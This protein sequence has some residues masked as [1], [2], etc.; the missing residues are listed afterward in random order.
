MSRARLLVSIV[1]VCACG[2]GET[3]AD[4]GDPIDGG[5]RVDSTV[6]DAGM[7]DAGSADVDSGEPPIDAG[8]GGCTAAACPD[9]WMGGVNLAGADFGETNLPGVYDTHYIYPSPS[10]V[11]Y[12]VGRGMRAIR[13]PFRW[14]RLQR[15]LRSA[16]DATELARMESIVR[17]ATGLGARVILDPH[18][19]ARYHGALVGTSE[20]SN[21]DYADL[22]RRLALVFADDDRVIFGL[23]NE[24]HTMPTEQ[25]LAAANAAIAAIRGAGAQN[26]I[27]VP[28]NSYTGAFSWADS[29][30]GTPNAEVML[31]V[32]DP[33][34]RYAI[35]VHQYLDADS[36][37]RGA[38]CVSGTIGRERTV[39]FTS[40][41]RDN[42]LRGFLGE[43]GGADNAACEAA[44]HDLLSFIEANAD[45]WLGWTWWAAGPWWGDYM[46][47]IEPRGD[48]SDS[49]QMLWLDDHL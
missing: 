48:G 47:S 49:P 43:L 19:Y 15:S 31:G 1:W 27:L 12:F 9:E 30:Y 11:D 2:G 8:P 7:D 4:G 25:W 41:L 42:G 26:L 44:V 29:W 3:S 17:Y 10:E 33:M 35:E 13:L 22:W 28:G 24:P 14:E 32:I 18:N 5:D 40:W 46:F 23:M 21:D 38:E 45:V 34:D 16:L 39:L 6:A 20:L 37:G 36:S